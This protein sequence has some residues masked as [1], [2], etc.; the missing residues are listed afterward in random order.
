MSEHQPQFL[1]V[2]DIHWPFVGNQEK[3]ILLTG[4]IIRGPLRPYAL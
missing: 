3:D 1:K 4:I 2:T